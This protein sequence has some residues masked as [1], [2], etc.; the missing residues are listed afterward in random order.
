MGGWARPTRS[1][2]AATSAAS[3][4]VRAGPVMCSTVS[5]ALKCTV[6]SP[7][8]T[9]LCE[10]LFQP[11][12]ASLSTGHLLPLLYRAFHYST[13]LYSIVLYCVVPAESQAAWEYLFQPSSSLSRGV[14][15][16]WDLLPAH[17]REVQGGWAVQCR[18]RG[19]VWYTQQLGPRRSSA[20]ATA[21]TPTRWGT[22]EVNLHLDILYLCSTP[23]LQY[24]M[25]RATVGPRRSSATA[26]APTPTR[27]ATSEVRPRLVRPYLNSTI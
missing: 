4:K 1:P 15:Q 12:G 20:T 16:H 5:A 21:P 6:L 11:S 18:D 19:G 2:G 13:L 8:Y 9:R 26:T 7:R 22:S 14:P 24:S 10:H 17:G 23:T 25:V 3:P 27:W